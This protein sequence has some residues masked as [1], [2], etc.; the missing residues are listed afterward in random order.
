[1]KV[2]MVGVHKSTKGGMWAV[3]ENYLNDEEFVNKYDLKYISTAVS[4]S[5]VKRLLYSGYG[6]LKVFFYTLF[7]DYDLLHVH[8]S[9]RM[10]VFRKGIIIKVAQLRHPKI[11]IHMHGAEFEEWY[12][13]LSENKQKKVRKILNNA[14][15]ILIL[16][17]YW[18]EFVSSLIDDKTKIQ[19]MYNSVYCPK[20]NLYNIES[21]NLLF[22]GAVG[23]RKGIFDLIE[24]MKII[25]SKKINTK[26]MLYGPDVTDGITEI[27]KKNNLEDY[28]E[29]KG[30]LNNNEKEKL[31]SSQ[32]ALNIL[33]S[34]N[35]GLPMT[36][37]ETMSY[38]IPNISTNVAAIPEV[39]NDN[40]GFINIPGDYKRIADNIISFLKDQ[41]L[42]K[43]LS[44][45]SY[46]TINNF[47]SIE[48]H[49]EKLSSVYDEV[50]K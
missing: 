2:L 15:R 5:V 46:E 49:I 23:K 31:F 38:G 36:I 32:I 27:I 11:I 43:R 39:I 41:K 45:N 29:Y 4:G 40:N 21:N 25:K 8:M 42:R 20:K 30:W 9:E 16:G 10:S 37:L 28:I 7:H 6:I 18:R 48:K 3:V 17:E 33:P 19:I 35:E 1:M 24:T 12:K 22:L 34:Y 47:F 14:D 26:L 50:V 13:E 44:E